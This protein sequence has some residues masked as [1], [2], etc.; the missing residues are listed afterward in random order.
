MKELERRWIYFGSGS[1]GSIASGSVDGEAGNT[2]WSK[3]VHCMMDREKEQGQDPPFKV[4][5]PKSSYTTQKSSIM[6]LSMD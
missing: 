6:N 2:L 5:P 4:T 3:A 1:L